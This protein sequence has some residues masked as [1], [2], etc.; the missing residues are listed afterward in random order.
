MTTPTYRLIPRR[1][2]EPTPRLGTFERV[3]Y[4]LIL[5]GL[6]LGCV[7]GHMYVSQRVAKGQMPGLVVELHLPSIQR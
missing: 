1:K 6:L 7:A 5:G 2:H 4:A 3:L